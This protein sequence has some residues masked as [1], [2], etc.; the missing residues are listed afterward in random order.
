MGL[1]IMASA[2]E[3]IYCTYRM[4]IYKYVLWANQRVSLSPTSILETYY[5]VR[6]KIESPDV[7]FT[8][9]QNMVSLC[10]NGCNERVIK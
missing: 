7:N 5:A 1:T 10:K 4:I 9:I 8:Y 6:L 2:I 3:W